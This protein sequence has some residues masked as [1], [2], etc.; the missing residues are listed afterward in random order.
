MTEVVMKD[1]LP[2]RQQI[3]SLSV[4]FDDLIV[5]ADVR[6]V[7]SRNEEFV[8]QAG[9]CANDKEYRWF[10]KIDCGEIGCMAYCSD[11][12]EIAQ[13]GADL[14]AWLFLFDDKVGEGPD[15]TDPEKLKSTL[16][17]YLDVCESGSPGAST[18]PFHS[19]LALLIA[20]GRQMA[21]DQWHQKFI[22]SFQCYFRGLMDECLA[23]NGLCSLDIDQYR[24]IR[25]NSIAGYPV[26]DL[27]D[28]QFGRVID[29]EDLTLLRHKTADLL[30]WVND[31]CSIDKETFDSD[32]INVA[33]VI[34]NDFSLP[35]DLAVDRA[36]ELVLKPD[37]ELF[38]LR[39]QKI[40]SGDESPEVKKYAVSLGHWVEAT[41]H[42][43]MKTRRYTDIHNDRRV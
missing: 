35:F 16:D 4:L 14:I 22:G 29:S 1:L 8:R 30:G 5:T 15:V 41:Y 6:R 31:L 17:M 43:S 27:I 42:W 11:P 39:Q 7:R 9:I 37:W 36:I 20:R 33:S 21:G 32:P 3:E 10:L 18:D 40:F 13:F 38:K 19:S 34:A 12:E 28:L 26:L 24:K 23:R 25:R 2:A